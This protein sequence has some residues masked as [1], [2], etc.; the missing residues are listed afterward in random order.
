MIAAVLACPAPIASASAADVKDDDLRKIC[1]TDR[2]T[3]SRVRVNRICL[4]R[5][6][7]TR[8]EEE[9]RKGLEMLGRNGSLSPCGPHPGVSQ[10]GCGGQ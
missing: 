1:K 2:A 9:K 4:T 7:W 8:L 3:G 6:Q 5:A 10:A